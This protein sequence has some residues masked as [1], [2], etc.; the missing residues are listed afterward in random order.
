[1]IVLQVLLIHTLQHT[2]SVTV[3][4]LASKERIIST[5]EYIQ[6]YDEI[7]NTVMETHSEYLG[8]LELIWH[9]T[10]PDPKQKRHATIILAIWLI[11]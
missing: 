6:H 10:H 7:K 5:N 2:G 8:Y 9:L 4:D 1:M 3:S 11:L